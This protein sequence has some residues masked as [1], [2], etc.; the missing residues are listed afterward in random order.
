MP[1]V[2]LKEQPKTE[3]KT[4]G[5]FSRLSQDAQKRTRQALDLT[6][7]VGQGQD[8]LSTG[9]QG[10]GLIAGSAADLIGNLFITGAGAVKDVGL[11]IYTGGDELAK[12]QIE[13]GA[14]DFAKQ[15]I[16]SP[17]GQAFADTAS[18]LASQ[19]EELKKTNPT[20]AANI[21]GAADIADFALNFTG[22]GVAKAGVKGAARSGKQLVGEAIETGVEMAQDVATTAAKTV[23]GSDTIKAAGTVLKGAGER[24]GEFVEQAP[25]RLKQTAGRMAEEKRILSE[26]PEVVR[27]AVGEGIPVG[28]AT[29]IANASPTEKTFFKRMVDDA[30][31]YVAG[32]KDL[33][34][35]AAAGEAFQARLKNADSLRQKWGEELGEMVKGL[36]AQEIPNVTDDVVS[37]MRRVPGLEDIR[38]LDDGT[39][40]FSKTTLST[41]QSAQNLINTRFKSIAGRDGLNLH[42]LRQEI[43]ELLGGKQKAGVEITATEEKA[44]NAM[45]SGLSEVLGNSNNQYRSLNEK[46][47]RIAQPLM[48]LNKFYKNL[49]DASDDL[50]NESSAILMRRLTGRSMSGVEMKNAIALIDKELAEVGIK[51]DINLTNIQEFVNLLDEVY[52]TTKKTG[53]AG[54]VELGTRGVRGMIEGAAGKVMEAA[55]QSEFTKREAIKSLLQ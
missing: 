44:L 5:F 43:F 42:R 22:A 37:S 31:G 9:V 26:A 35:A 52:G 1:F 39:L 14:S 46:Y 33:D 19:Y 4:G 7:R 8:P 53:L 40:D 29:F 24:V 48:R 15:V 10:A 27:K 55:G 18:K 16:E 28:E 2:P 32:N 17:A 30:E 49:P 45:S 21:K 51:S 3:A 41:N 12:K 36:K 23:D 38:L 13:K 11:D 47:A 54:Q 34:P 20:L 6:G 25:K 50:L